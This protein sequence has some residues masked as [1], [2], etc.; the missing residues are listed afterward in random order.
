MRQLMFLG[1]RQLQW[2]DAPDPRLEDA[3]GA[4]VRPV[5]VATCDLDPAIIRGMAP[6]PGPFPLGHECIADVVEVGAEVT[7]VRPGQRVVVPFQISCGTCDR[8][9]R[10]LTA[11]CRTV[12]GSSMD[13][14]GDRGGPWGGMPADLV[15]VPFADAVPV[16]LLP[17][18]PG[19]CPALGGAGRHLRLPS[20]Y[21][22]GGVP[23]PAFDRCNTRVDLLLGRGGLTGPEGE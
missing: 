19:L 11:N 23:V 7:A 10:G 4:L 17:G 22:D 20:V 12:P 18:G 21:W 6:F 5:A 14:M 1:P 13:G 9:L 16:L 2:R 3:A 15:H 8:C